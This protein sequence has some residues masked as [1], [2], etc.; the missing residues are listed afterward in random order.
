MTAEQL[1]GEGYCLNNLTATKDASSQAGRPTY[2]FAF[3]GKGNKKFT[4]NRFKCVVYCGHLP[5][6]TDLYCTPILSPGTAVII[7][8]AGAKVDPIKKQPSKG[9]KSVDVYNTGS[10]ISKTPGSVK[11][12]FDE[13]LPEEH[14][15]QYWR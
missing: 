11:I 10:I 13:P 15:S 2:T 5:T 6:Q 3:G 9:A 12:S 4:W 7:S 8:L 1:V 14:G